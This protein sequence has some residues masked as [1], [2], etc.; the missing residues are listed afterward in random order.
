MAG[1]PR[2]R[3]PCP[4]PSPPLPCLPDTHPAHRLRALSPAPQALP[5]LGQP[6]V[7]SGQQREAEEGLWGVPP[8]GRPSNIRPPFVLLPAWG[9]DAGRG[10]SRPVTV[11]CS[12]GSEE[13]Q[14]RDSRLQKTWVMGDYHLVCVL[15]LYIAVHTLT[16]ICFCRLWF[17]SF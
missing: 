10:H 9:A 8:G 5:L 13:G 7:P 2:A 14:S 17:V 3:T 16:S 12:V 1:P 11:I 15:Y 4:P 6:E